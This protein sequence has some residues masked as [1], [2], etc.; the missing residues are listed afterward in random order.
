MPERQSITRRTVLQTTGSS[1]LALG[2]TGLAS[3]APDDTVEVNVGFSGGAGRAAALDAADEVVREFVFDAATLRLPKK[4]ATALDRNPNVRYVEA[5]GLMEALALPWNYDRI[6]ADVSN[7]NGYTGDGAD[8]AV[9][10][11]GIDSDNGCLPNVGS[12]YAV[13]D[14]SGSSCNY[15]W[16]DD[17]GHGTQV[18][19]IIG[20]SESCSCTTGVAPDAT[21]HSVKV[22]ND[23]G[24]GSYSDIATG[25][26]YV[27]DQGWDV[28]NMSIGGSSGSQAIKDACQYAYDNGVLLVGAAG[29]SGPC[30]DSCVGYPAAY[31][32][33]IAVSATNKDDE[34][35]SF[36]SRG[37]EIELCAP[38]QDI[39]TIGMDGGCT[40]LSGTSFATAH[41]SGVGA[42]LAA[43]GYTNTG[44]RTH[45]QNTAE[46]LGLS[47]REQGYGLVDAAAAVGLDSSDD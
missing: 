31:S 45:M 14:C 37:S 40:T 12:G 9:L 28:A 11:T 2:A 8:V 41:V 43:E 38:G 18:A 42:L 6:D 39:T 29:G 34:L 35:A 23:W 36:S 33:V 46:D 27:A 13:V 22:L 10:D 26:E 25:I 21:L 44:A 32:E 47:A 20:A 19:G 15:T 4:A 1:L 7:V 5:N 16:D 24:S 17:N 3:A 30:S